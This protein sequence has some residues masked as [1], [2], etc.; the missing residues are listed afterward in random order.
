MSDK[1][2]RVGVIGLGKMGQPIARNLLKAGFPVTVHNRSSAATEAMVAAGATDGGSAKGVASGSDVII[3]SLPDPAAVRKVYLDA[4]GP[5][6]YTHLT[7][8]TICSV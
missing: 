5:V 3:T 4:D 1:Q 7:L 2:I 8:P 6:S